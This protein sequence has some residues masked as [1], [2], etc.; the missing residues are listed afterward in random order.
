MLRYGDARSNVSDERQNITSKQS[1]QKKKEKNTKVRT[2][3]KRTCR[4]VV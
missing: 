3:E 2:T 4:G 1:V